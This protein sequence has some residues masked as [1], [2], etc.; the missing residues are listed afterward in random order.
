MFNKVVFL[1]TYA[2]LLLQLGLALAM[3]AD[4]NGSQSGN[5]EVTVRTNMKLCYLIYTHLSN[6]LNDGNTFR[7]NLPPLLLYLAAG[8]LSLLILPMLGL[9]LAGPLPVT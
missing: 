6:V 8:L 9:V 4:S 5:Y 2:D 3:K 1:N 7:L